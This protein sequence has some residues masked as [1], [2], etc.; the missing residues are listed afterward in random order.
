MP[1]KQWR[2][3]LNRAMRKIK[4]SV[5]REVNAWNQCI[6][7]F[8]SLICAPIYFAPDRGADGTAAHGKV[9][10]FEKLVLEVRKDMVPP[11]VKEAFTGW[12]WAAP[13]ARWTESP[14]V[15]ELVA[16]HTGCVKDGAIT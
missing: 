16:L 1:L 6:A 3:V 11:R 5:A 7:V 15:G 8:E 9:L 4:D 12:W 14:C 13:G 2:L 10:K